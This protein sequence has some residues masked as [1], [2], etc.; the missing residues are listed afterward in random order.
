MKAIPREAGRITYSTNIRKLKFLPMNDI[1]KAVTIG[2]I[3]G[4]GNLSSNW[5]KTNYRL[6]ISHS[7]KQSEYILWKYEILKDFVLT[8]PNVYDKTKS[9]S[10][11]TISHSIFTEFYKLFYPLSKKVIPR[12]IEQLIK[13]PMTIAIW[14]MD[15]GNAVVRKDILRGYHL[16][17][18]SFTLSENK[19]LSECLYK[20]HKIESVMELNHGKY[21]IAI[22]KEDSRQKFRNL[23]APHVID[24]MK[25]KIG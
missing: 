9:I 21:R 1:Q 22:W 6:K 2:S 11:R 20:L 19:L 23:V 8:K 15:D 14:F 7:I 3:L 13:N 18:Q 4:D 24:S 12:N 25:Y 5:S 16:N 10:F 17:S